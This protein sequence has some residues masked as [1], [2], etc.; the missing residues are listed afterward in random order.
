MFFQKEKKMLTY[1][2]DAYPLL[3][4]EFWPSDWDKDKYD[5]TIVDIKEVFAFSAQKNIRLKMF[6]KGN[7]SMRESQPP[8]KFWTW[9]V[10][11]LLS[12]RS[13]FE[14]SLDKTAIYKPS[15]RLDTFVDMVLSMYKT[16]RPLEV[17]GDLQQAMAWLDE[18][19]S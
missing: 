11:D 17:F 8:F 3:L 1:N 5:Q 13:T 4:I 7:T 9:L 16:V 14:T 15:D 19:S 6:V 10:R 12:M 18:A 2:I